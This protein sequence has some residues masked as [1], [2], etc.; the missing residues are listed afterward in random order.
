MKLDKMRIH[1]IVSAALKEDLGEG[2]I[3]TETLIPKSLKTKAVII[4]KEEGIVAGLPVAK[5]VFTIVDPSIRF[6]S[7]AKDGNRV[8]EN[9]VIAALKGSAR[10]ILK[11]ERV[12]LNFLSR[13][14]GIATLT[15]KYVH[16]V[17]KCGVKMV[18]I[19]NTRKTTPGLRYLERYA[20][21]VGGGYNHRETLSQQFLVKDGH[22]ELIYGIKGNR[23]GEAIK[24]IISDAKK[25]MSGRKK[26]EIEV[27]TLEE[28]G[29]A[30]KEKP[31]IIMLD[32]MNPI[33]VRKAVTMRNNLGE[34]PLLEA[35][36]GITLKNVKKY[37]ER[38]VDMIS[39]GELTH[40]P[41]SLD[42]ALEIRCQDSDW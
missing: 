34:R 24:K 30:L 9:T 35:S 32:N 11:A 33:D 41:K 15:S 20:V 12:A 31:D 21:R 28:F 7:L 36:G 10:S 37:A 5:L 27:C 29:A 42:M 13:L 25:A 19:M 39:I 22:L 40:S 23:R 17:K 16:R 8:G 2:D 14:S 26:I 18:K 4:A 3:T 1:G 38:G 6:K